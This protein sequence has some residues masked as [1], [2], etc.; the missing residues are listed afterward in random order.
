[1]DFSDFFALMPPDNAATVALGNAVEFPQDGPSSGV[2]TRTGP[3]SFTLPSV[4]VYLV[5][6]QVSVSEAGQLV[7]ALDEGA[8][9]TTIPTSTV[10]RANGSSQIVGI[11]LVTTTVPD[12]LL[13]VVNPPGNNTALTIT[14]LAGGSSVVSAHLAIMRIR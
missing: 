11:S 12:S 1:V 6:F 7:L 4:G 10:G 5:Q 13:A 8:G 9:L 14:P 3:S 2:I